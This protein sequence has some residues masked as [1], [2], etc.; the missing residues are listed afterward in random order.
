MDGL[1]LV[2]KPRGITSGECV[3][4]VRDILKAGKAGHSGSLDGNASGI[5]LI[6]LGRALNSMELLMGLDK[7]YEGVVHMHGDFEGEKLKLIA[8]KFTGKIK[9]TPPRRSAVARRPRVREIYSL[10][11]MKISGR[12]VYFRTRT[13]A[14]VYIRR[15]AA[16]MGE[17]LGVKAHLKALRRTGIGPFK[18]KDCTKLEGLE[19]GDVIPLERVLNKIG[20][21][22]YD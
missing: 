22:W 9:Q 21:R 12:D 16:D 14:G 3:R 8:R 13:Q 19:K 7:E 17:A 2:D 10:E 5:L 18:L 1:V 11:I 4:R 15:F 6:A 20:K